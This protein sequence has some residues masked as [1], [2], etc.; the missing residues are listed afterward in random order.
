MERSAYSRRD[1]LKRAG[2]ATVGV[3]AVLGT[4]ER[5]RGKTAAND[6][7]TI[8]I[9]GTGSRGS[10]LLQIINTI[11]GLRVA[12]VCDVYPPH[13]E[14]GLKL[15]GGKVPAYK[16]Y[17]Q[18]LEQKD[19]DSVLI[20]T[21]LRFHA[22]MCID[23]MQAGK[24][25]FCEKTMTY[26]IEEA[27]EVVQWVRRTNRVFQ[28]G[29]QRRYSPVYHQAMR[30]IREGAIGEVV[31]IRAQWHRNADWRRAVPDPSLEKHLNWRLY[32]EFSGGLMTELGTHQIDVAN[33]ALGDIHPESCVGMG[34]I[35]YWRDGR[36]VYDNVSVIYK[37]PNG[38]KLVYTSIT[39]NKFYGASE[40]IM[41]SEGTIELTTSRAKVYRENP[42]RRSEFK[43][44][45]WSLER[46]LFQTVAIGT[47]TF[48]PEDPNADRGTWIEPEMP[49]S[50]EYL[51][52]ESF[53]ECVRTRK[54][55]FADVMVGYNAGVAALIGNQAMDT[56]EVVLWPDHEDIA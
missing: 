27:R 32:R 40:Q 31:F 38:V 19:L 21:P 34:G 28:V 41:G 29:Q 35:D 55:P 14:R 33:W 42:A 13:L 44:F 48:L 49:H 23:A 15:A 52:L 10:H 45:V 26:S 46:E 17:R 1:F 37:Y 30:L 56:G 43:E 25:V 24:D 47:A 9:I 11:P 54:K 5:A 39:R 7:V 51:Q 18:M 4:S 6:V 20:A 3:A 22:R 8:G 53:A 50:E 2:L 16:D 36:E 12:A